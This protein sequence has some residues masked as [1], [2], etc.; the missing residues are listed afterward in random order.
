MAYEDQFKTT[1]YYYGI[2]N[3]LI[4]YYQTAGYVNAVRDWERQVSNIADLPDLRYLANKAQF[5]YNKVKNS[6]LYR[7]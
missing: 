3:R 7:K 1:A 4:A 6:P 2:I 5:M